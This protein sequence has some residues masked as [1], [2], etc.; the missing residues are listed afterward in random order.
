M[1][2]M[3]K[4][5]RFPGKKTPSKIRLEDFFLQRLPDHQQYCDLGNVQFTCASCGNVSKFSFTGVVF[6][7]CHFYCSQCGVG[8]KLNNPL[9]GRKRGSGSQ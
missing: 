1:P 2:A 3:G 9:F 7:E 5:I 6:R 8:Y 4:L